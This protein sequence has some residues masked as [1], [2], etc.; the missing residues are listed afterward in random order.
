MKISIVTINYNGGKTLKRTIESI[1]QQSYNEKFEYIIVDGKSTDNS[2]EIIKE[3]QNKFLERNVLYKWVSESDSGIY[4]AMNKGIAL[5]SGKIIGLLNSDDWYERDT[6]KKVIENFENSN[7]DMLYGMLR[8][9]DNERFV[10][11]KG[12][13]NIYGINYHPTVFIKKKIYKKYGNYNEK[14]KI[15]ADA[16]LL[17]R[18]KKERVKCKFIENI[19]ANFSITGISNK[20]FFKGNLEYIE[21][22]YKYGEYS[23][24][25]AI[26]KYIKLI[27]KYLYVNFLK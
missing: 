8:Y 13:Y 14:Y 20:N 5:S 19:L 1:Y 12:E 17:L 6:L 10:M 9:V 24:K 23:L 2:L 21:I 15:A 27:I 16:D 18:L 26:L 11:I 7:I 25:Q 3:Y 22:C 4:N